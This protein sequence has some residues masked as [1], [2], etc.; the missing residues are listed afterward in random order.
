MRL[1]LNLSSLVTPA[2]SHTSP[3]SQAMTSERAERRRGGRRCC[4]RD[5][6]TGTQSKGLGANR[7]KKA[8]ERR[9]P[10]LR[11]PAGLGMG[12]LGQWKVLVMCEHSQSLSVLT[13][14]LEKLFT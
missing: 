7:R 6:S 13:L 2:Q 8:K 9:P 4:C 12:C 5:G 10:N 3:L 1:L 14:N 11:Q